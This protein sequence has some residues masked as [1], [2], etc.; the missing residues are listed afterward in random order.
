MADTRVPELSGARVVVF[1]M[2]RSGLR[3]AELAVAAGA[4]SVVCTDLRADAPVVPG[5]R[6]VY[7]RHD[8]GD[9]L[10]ADLVVLSPGIPPHLPLLQA[11]RDAA[12][13]VRSELDVATSVLEQFGVRTLAVTGTNG[14]SSTVWLLHQVLL[15]A[16][17]TSWVGGNLG[18]PVSS[19]ALQLVTGGPAPD[20]AVIEV[21]SYQLENTERYRPHAAAVLNLTPDHLARHKTMVAYARAKMQ[22]F[23]NQA[24]GDL[25]VLPAD[26]EYLC[27]AALPTSGSTVR[28]TGAQPGVQVTGD[29]LE[30]G[31]QT[32]DLSDFP[33]PG[34]HNRRNLGA[35][36][37][38]ARHVGIS[39][40]RIRPG[41]LRPLPHRMEA[42]HT[43]QRGVTFVNDS[44]ATNVEAAL[45][46]I[47]A[48]SQPTV[49]LL[50]G[51]GKA[52]AD[53]QVLAPDLQ[54]RAR[55]VIC[56]GS[57]GPVISAQLT[58]ANVAND[59]VPSL[60]DALLRAR[61]VSKPGDTILLSPACAS[62]DAYSDFEA[63]GHHFTDLARTPAS[64]PRNEPAS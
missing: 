23:Q 28:W 26:D 64:R 25:A 31:D 55:R 40:H 32:L 20:F 43:D 54:A 8:V 14:K 22:L 36:L 17:H 42:V 58:D 34:L 63:R 5:T 41:D 21:S 24:A 61:A 50:G 7:G 39:P 33:L 3:A 60:P 10:N 1:G 6:S 47:Q 62:F 49:F 45:V 27:R 59:C 56:F 35:A 52:G 51:Q 30:F 18:D 46:G 38:L 9:L 37:L 53:Y 29:Q 13:P 57:A 48:V 16:G 44:K 19:L 2:A 15:Q 4:D 11:A 12:V